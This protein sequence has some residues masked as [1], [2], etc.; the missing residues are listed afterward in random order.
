MERI[1]KLVVETAQGR[2]SKA[3]TF[4]P[5]LRYLRLAATKRVID[6]IEARISHL[7]AGV[8]FAERD[9][10]GLDCEDY[11]VETR[12]AMNFLRAACRQRIEA[13]LTR[14][15][16][17][18]PQQTTK[19]LR[20]WLFSAKKSPLSRGEW[21]NTTAARKKDSDVKR[22]RADKRFR[23]TLLAQLR[24]ELGRYRNH[25]PGNLDE[26]IALSNGWSTVNQQVK[27]LRDKIQAI[28]GKDEPRKEWA[29][30]PKR[31]DLPLTT[32]DIP[33]LKKLGINWSSAGKDLD[34]ESTRTESRH[35]YEAGSTEWKN[36]APKKYNRT[37]NNWYVR[38]LIMPD[39]KD[40]RTARAIVHDTTYTVTLPEG[41]R[42][43]IDEVGV[44]A[45]DPEGHEFHPMSR[46]IARRDAA[47]HIVAQITELAAKRLADTR[48]A[49]SV[50]RAELE[51][52]MICL[53][54]SLRAGN[55]EAGT[56]NFAVR[57]GLDPAR[58]YSPSALLRVANGDSHRVRLAVAVGLR[59]HRH[60]MAQGFAL[61]EDHR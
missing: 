30:T 36:G 17:E 12:S 31:S 46:D 54:D 28:T 13:N 44:A 9:R 51:G 21:A 39:R 42:W 16:A 55:C 43:A 25:V 58:H 61:L 57:H 48:A 10:I 18:I 47:A 29:W 33:M 14:D 45:F 52:A 1:K 15:T 60:E 3:S 59:R 5:A 24:R 11:S 50:E 38:T 37:V 6:G 8:Y 7:V 34:V 27:V 20:S 2:G 32:E 23:K 40:Q 19:L 53:R 4:R 22:A 41:Y 35:E 26:A 49:E 56:R